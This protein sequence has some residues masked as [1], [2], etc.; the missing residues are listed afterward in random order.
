M[1]K[2]TT[3]VAEV[4]S[5]VFLRGGVE[6]KLADGKVKNLDGTDAVFPNANPRYFIPTNLKYANG[7]PV[8]IDMPRGRFTNL[9]GRSPSMEIQPRGTETL[10][11]AMKVAE[12]LRSAYSA[13]CCGR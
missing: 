9:F 7:E 11:E 12:E 3:P 8:F 6:A 10:E 5:K 4:S 2:D 13:K 1:A